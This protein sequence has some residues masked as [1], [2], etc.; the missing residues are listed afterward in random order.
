M[1]EMA[2]R[3]RKRGTESQAIGRSRGGVTTRI[4]ALTD[5]LG[6]LVRFVPL[7]GQRH[8]FTRSAA[9]RSTW[10]GKPCSKDPHRRFVALLDSS[11]SASDALMRAGSVAG[12]SLPERFCRMVQPSGDGPV[13][14][15][16]PCIEAT[17]LNLQRESMTIHAVPPSH[18]SDLLLRSGRLHVLIFYRPW[19]TVAALNTSIQGSAFGFHPD[20]ARLSISCSIFN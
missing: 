4:L 1:A 10:T 5:A 2:R 3:R 16:C 15:V 8:D 11:P 19:C 13:R 12:S 6:T 9:R 20:Q 14:P 17:T 7:P 18:Q